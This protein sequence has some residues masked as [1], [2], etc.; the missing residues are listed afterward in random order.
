[1]AANWEQIQAQ[2]P[3]LKDSAL[4]QW[5]MLTDDDWEQIDGDRDKLVGILQGYYEW[6][7]TEASRRVDEFFSQRGA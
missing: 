4:Q 1:M 2:W 5:S 3:D 7:S 6:D